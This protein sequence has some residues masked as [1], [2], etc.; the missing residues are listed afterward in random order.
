[1]LN[2]NPTV[3]VEKFTAISPNLDHLAFENLSL[4]IAETDEE[5]IAAQKL[6]YKVFYEEM[7]ATPTEEMQYL[8]REVEKY[9]PYCQHLLVID[10]NLPADQRVVGTYRL[11]TLED[12]TNFGISLY[13]E[14]E[15]DISKLKASGKRIMEVSRSCVLESHRSKM[16]INMLWRG[17]ADCVVANDVDYLIGVPSLMGTDMEAHKNTLSYLQA[18][19]LADE[20][21]CP[22][23]LVNSDNSLPLP[24]GNKDVL[25][26]K[27][28]FV[29]L[30]PLLKGYI[31]LGAMVGNG[32]Y[33][34]R[35]FNTIDVVIIVPMAQM[36]A[37]YLDRYMP[38]NEK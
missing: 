30:P 4:K 35:Q 17:I 19:H 15:F 38:K 14:S 33:I 7:G 29:K 37:R 31:R 24:I 22:E 9:D 25:D 26:A 13:T 2:L 27:R 18:Y 5:I 12:A 28:E 8:G 36:D 10:N 32:V 1:M 34:D 11:L 16:V 6:R 20:N 23:M 3:N 21:L